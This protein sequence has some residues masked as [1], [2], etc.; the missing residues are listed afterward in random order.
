MVGVRE[1]WRR[2]VRVVRLAD[3]VAEVLDA[4]IP[5]LTR[6]PRLERLVARLD[7]QLIL[8][9]NKADLVPPHIADSWRRVLNQE[10]PTVCISARRGVAVLRRLIEKLAKDLLRRFRYPRIRVGIVGYPNVGK[11][12]IINALAS[13]YAAA[14]SPV[15]GFTRGEAFIRLADRIYLIDTPGVFPPVGDSTTRMMCGAAPPESLP[16]P[17]PPALDIIKLALS[18]NPRSLYRLYRTDSRVR[19]PLAVLEHVARWRGLVRK[20][21]VFDIEEAARIVI[22]DWQFGNLVFWYTPEEVGY[23]STSSRSE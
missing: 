7:K 23:A 18:R 12:S 3:I 13:R 15:P 22:R 17:V 9:I 2:V 14:T 21:G 16:D 4:R 10:H 1:A 8:V 6:Y 20:G 11:S 5:H 19:D